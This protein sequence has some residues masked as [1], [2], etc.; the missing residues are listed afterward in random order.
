MLLRGTIRQ[1]LL[2]VVRT[3]LLP[4]REG[5][6]RPE[7]LP[8]KASALGRRFGSLRNEEPKTSKITSFRG[9]MQ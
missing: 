4:R 9:T 3:D 7:K 5:D 1:R 6:E 2:V 8:P